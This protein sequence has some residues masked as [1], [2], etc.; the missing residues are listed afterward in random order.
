MEQQ[1]ELYN[2]KCN[3]LNYEILKRNNSNLKFQNNKY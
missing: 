3:K 2:F 1:I